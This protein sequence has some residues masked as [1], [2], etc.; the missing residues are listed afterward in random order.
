MS[1]T[2]TIN[3]LGPLTG[4][5]CRP[6]MTGYTCERPAFYSVNATQEQTGTSG[7]SGVCAEHLF[8]TIGHFLGLP[9]SHAWCVTWHADS[10]PVVQ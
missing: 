9:E 1:Y 4:S 6:P 10:H 5:T 7:G 3:V 2:V 8:A